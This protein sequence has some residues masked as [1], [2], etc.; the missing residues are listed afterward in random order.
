VSTEEARDRSRAR[1]AFGIGG[2]AR[3]EGAVRACSARQGPK[4]SQLMVAKL[5]AMT[6]AVSQHFV[7]KLY[8][9]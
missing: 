3:A 9:C 8:E 4:I 5:H 1:V 2:D 6:Q 7:A